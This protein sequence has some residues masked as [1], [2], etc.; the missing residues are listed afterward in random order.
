MSVSSQS[1]PV[2]SVHVLHEELENCKKNMDI[3]FL[4]VMGSI[5]FCEFLSRP[6]CKYYR[7][8]FFQIC[9]RF[10][11]NKVLQTG[12]AFYESGSVRSKNV[13]NV[14]FLNYVDTSL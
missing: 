12:F 14:L 5:V 4:I 7:H 13:T 2:P 8:F 11:L 9:P 3:F 1:D 10:L 6:L